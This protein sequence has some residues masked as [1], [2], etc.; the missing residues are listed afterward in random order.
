M[1]AYTPAL[2]EIPPQQPLIEELLS[3]LSDRHVHAIGAT[4]SRFSS[5]CQGYE[6]DPVSLI[7][8]LVTNEPATKLIPVDGYS[9]VGA[10]ILHRSILIVNCALDA[11]ANNIV[12]AVWR[13][14]F[15]VKQYVIE[16]GN[17]KRLYSRPKN[18]FGVPL[19]I[20]DEED[21]NVWGVAT[22]AIIPLL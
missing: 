17:R 21:V 16:E 2:L 22:H 8:E 3:R 11:I 1:N 9:M 12:V 4:Q 15:V 18:H 6:K 5:P 20:G 7:R 19:P 14:S 13:G 10:G